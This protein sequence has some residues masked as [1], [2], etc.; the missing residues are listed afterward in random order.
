MFLT[1]RQWLK[2]ISIPN[3]GSRGSSPH[4]LWCSVFLP[5]PVCI[6]GGPA[7]TEA[8]W[9]AVFGR[10]SVRQ[11]VPGKCKSYT[12]FVTQNKL[13]G[14]STFYCRVNIVRCEVLRLVF[15]IW[16]GV[17]DRHVSVFRI[18]PWQASSGL[19]QTTWNYI[20]EYCKLQDL[21]L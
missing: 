19:Y 3:A 11:Y 2:S 5:L 20:S 16:I 7:R 1:L 6:E 13:Y 21:F 18:K 4:T 17:P 10:G 8:V 9:N 14:H 15:V 12:V